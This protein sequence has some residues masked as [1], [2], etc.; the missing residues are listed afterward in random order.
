[1]RTLVGTF[2]ITVFLLDSG[3]F[4]FGG[5]HP[6]AFADGGSREERRASLAK[7]T[8][9]VLGPFRWTPPPSNSDDKG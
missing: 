2:L 8:V 1:M 6:H 4:L 7:R 3:G 5:P 9:V